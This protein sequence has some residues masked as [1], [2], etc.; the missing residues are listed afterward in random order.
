VGHRLH[1]EPPGV[2]VFRP[3]ALEARLLGSEKPGSYR[4]SDALGNLV[5]KVENIGHSTV[6]L[7]RPEMR[8]G[9]R[10]NQLRSDAQPHTCL[11]HSALQ[12]VTHSEVFGHLTDVDGPALVGKT[13]IAR[14]FGVAAV[15]VH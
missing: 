15:G 1:D 11:A 7:V 4:R 14:P 12:D 13:R 3:L 10:F 2:Q 8:S 5:L 6:E 9:F